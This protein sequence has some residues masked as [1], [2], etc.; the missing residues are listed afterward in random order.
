MR[1][2]SLSLDWYRVL[3]TQALMLV[4]I[5]QV[6]P[7]SLRVRVDADRVKFPLNTGIAQPG[8]TSPF[9]SVACTFHLTSIRHSGRWRGP[10]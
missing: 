5:S 2:V 4:G 7:L 9:A 10:D 6:C 3:M 1:P 8:C